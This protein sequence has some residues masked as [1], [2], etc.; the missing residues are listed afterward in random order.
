MLRQKNRLERERLS[1]DRC[2][3]WR[4]TCIAKLG[5]STTRGTICPLGFCP[6]STS[7]APHVRAQ[8]ASGIALPR[9]VS[10]RLIF[11][12]YKSRNPS[13]RFAADRTSCQFD[14]LMRVYVL[15]ALALSHTTCSE[16]CSRLRDR[17]TKMNETAIGSQSGSTGEL[18]LVAGSTG[19]PWRI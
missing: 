5:S 15:H 16:N 8:A 4:C 2:R 17:C 9:T 1:A 10:L 12:R 7:M 19:T 14:I 3:G 13:Q 18:H 11:S 6:T